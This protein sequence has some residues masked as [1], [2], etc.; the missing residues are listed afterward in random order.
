MDRPAFRICGH[1][2]AAVNGVAQHIEHTAQHLTAHRHADALT[3]RCHFHAAGQI[4]CGRQHD[5]AHRV[6]P[7]LLRHLHHA[8][9]AVD[10]DRQRFPDVRQLPF[11]K[12]H[13][14]DG[15]CNCDNFSDIHD[16]LP[17]ACCFCRF[18]FWARAPAETSVISC[19]MAA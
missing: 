15:A 10:A 2:R 17:C 12:F 8:A 14:H 11:L 18:R 5:A 19:V 3:V 9:L 1:G 13:V 7:D 4:F 16:S 6:V